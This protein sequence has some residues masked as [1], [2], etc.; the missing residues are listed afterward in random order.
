MKC[1][2]DKHTSFQFSTKAKYVQ[3]NKWYNKISDT[4]IVYLIYCI[5][6]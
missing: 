5:L 4:I 6:L 2:I 1:N 3:D